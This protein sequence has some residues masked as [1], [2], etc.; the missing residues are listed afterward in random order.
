MSTHRVL[1]LFIAAF[2]VIGLAI[3]ISS[4]RHLEHATLSGDPVLPGLEHGINDVTQVRLR[5]GDGTQVTLK[6]EAEG[7]SVAER[8]WPAQVSK[9]RKLLLD[10]GALNVVEEKT[11]LAANYPALGVEDL[12]TP[13]AAGVQI[14]ATA[15]AR[16]W[17][18]IIGK[19]AGAK[20]GYVRLAGAPASLLAAPL[21]MPEADPK[22]WLE[23][24][25]IDLPLERVRE[26]EEHPS[27]GGA[28]TLSRQKTDDPHFQVQPLPNGRELNGPAA[29]D[30]LAAALSGLSLLDVAKAPPTPAAA[31]E[32]SVFRTFDGLEIEVTGR[33]DGTRAV[34]ALH[35]H[36]AQPAASDEARKLAAHVD[37]WEFE[38]PEYKYAALFTPV[39]Q[40]LKPL[41]EPAKKQ[42]QA[43]APAPAPHP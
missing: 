3:W 13:K 25:I 26:V 18:I 15:P 17:D 1:G 5:K 27:Q 29:A 6:K 20:S 35:A 33:K 7:W 32:R 31:T 2:A 21:L 4:Q 36:A 22:L 42:P 12:G 43:K 38:I 11:R 28:Y 14:T 24:A 23:T 30:S 39:T 34:I 40:L 10:L 37:G 9:V 16:T 19:P 41:P 8:S